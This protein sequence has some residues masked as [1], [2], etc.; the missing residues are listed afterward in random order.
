MPR[1]KL[2]VLKIGDVWVLKI[3]DGRVHDAPPPFRVFELNRYIA[4]DKI[5]S[6]SRSRGRL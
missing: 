1:V 5:F 3:G 6:T 2:W 4:L